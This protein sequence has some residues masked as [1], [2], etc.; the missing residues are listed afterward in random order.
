MRKSGNSEH[1]ILMIPMNYY[2][3]LNC[4]NGTVV[5]LAE[6]VLSFKDT[7]KYLQMKVYIICDLLQNNLGL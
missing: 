1:R 7:Q 2:Y 5:M 3:F 4:D 6:R